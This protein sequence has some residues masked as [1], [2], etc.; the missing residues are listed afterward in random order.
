MLWIAPV[1]I[2]DAFKFAY[3]D[4]FAIDDALSEGYDPSIA[5]TADLPDPKDLPGDKALPDSGEVRETEGV[6]K[7]KI[8]EALNFKCPYCEEARLGGTSSKQIPP[9]SLRPL[10]RA[11]EQVGLDV[12]ECAVPNIDRKIKFILFIDMATRHKVTES[13]FDYAHG[14]V[15]IEN[16]DMVIQAITLRWL[17]DKPRPQV[18]IPDNA[19][20]LV[21]QKFV[22]FMMRLESKSFH[23]LTKNLGRMALWKECARKAKPQVAYSKLKNTSIRQPL[24]TFHP[25]QP[26][27]VWRKYLPE[28]QYKGRRGGKL[29]VMRPRWIGPGRVVMHELVPGQT[30]GDRQQVVWVALGNK[31]YR[32]SVHSVRPLSEREQEVFLAKG[33]DS[34]R[35]KE[36]KDMIPS[37]SYIDVTHEEPHEEEREEP[38]LPKQPNSESIAPPQVRFNGKWP[39]DER[40]LPILPFQPPRPEGKPPLVS[41][42]AP[43][44]EV[45]NEYEHPAVPLDFLRRWRRRLRIL[46]LFLCLQGDRALPSEPEPKRPRLDEDE[47]NDM[48][49]DLNTA[50]QE[51]DYGYLME[52]ELDFSSER[53][54]KI[55]MRNP[56]AYMVKKMSSAEVNYKKLS[57]EDKALFRNAKASEVSSLLKAEAVRRCLSVEGGQESERE[58]ERAIQPESVHTADGRRKAKARIVVM[59]FEHPDL[60]D[61]SFNNT[62]PVQ[63]QLMRNLSL[64]MVAQQKWV[65]EG[66]DLT[67]AFLQTGKTEESRE[68]WT[69]GVSELRAALGAEDHEV[70]RILK[71]IYGNATAPRGLWE[72]IDRDPNN[73]LNANEI[74]ACRAALGAL[75]WA[76]TQTQVQICARVNLLLTE[77]TVIKTIQVAR[78]IQDLIKEVRGNSVTLKMW[79]MPE[80]QHWQDA[81]VVTL[82]DQ[83]HNNRPQ[84]GS[85]GGLMAF[86][87]GPQPSSSKLY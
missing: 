75:Q 60:L 78:E 26:V 42:P 67:T 83:A 5:D 65:L 49:M 40:G 79:H 18:L 80:I 46:C 4:V 38:V 86:V 47:K 27:R 22:D 14:E 13:L 70:L 58:R 35:W 63:S 53:Q 56:Q 12:G 45:V 32:A 82:A 17:M 64:C 57:E 54:K 11:W 30:E 23:L 52:I 85:T 48:V 68:I 77:L 74:S 66:L 73:E 19:K 51:I 69:Y 76:A 71:N 50:I 2:N 34:S 44:A 25:A 39:I 6:E 10:P 16:A 3:A 87:A 43:M 72:D 7:W 33:D 84:R 9:A 81:V 29:K 36:L 37:R 61:P 8:K 28:N 41:L 59:G 1:E 20:S 62:A 15:K 55:F 21:S 31:M 24:R